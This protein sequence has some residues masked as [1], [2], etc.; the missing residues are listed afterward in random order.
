MRILKWRAISDFL[1][2][3]ATDFHSKPGELRYANHILSGDVIG[4]GKA[5]F[6]VFV[7]AACAGGRQ[8]GRLHSLD[9]L[10][11]EIAALVFVPSP[12][13]G[14]GMNESPQG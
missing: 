12:L 3:G 2:I 10:R 13:A 4:D 1:F 14:E 6:E 9:L 8:D 5:D 7:N 11:Q